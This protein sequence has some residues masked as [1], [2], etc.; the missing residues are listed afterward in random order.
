MTFI[1]RIGVKFSVYD[2]V[3]NELLIIQ[4]IVHKILAF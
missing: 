4:G 2:T 1:P 3:R